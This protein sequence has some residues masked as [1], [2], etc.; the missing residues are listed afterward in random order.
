M[1]GIIVF[2]VALV[3]MFAWFIYLFAKDPANLFKRDAR[4]QRQRDFGRDAPAEDCIVTP[5][6]ANRGGRDATDGFSPGG[7]DFGGA[8]SSGD[9]NNDAGSDGSGSSD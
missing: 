4:A 5:F 9:W 3:A 6:D 2:L 7:G 8:G 1:M